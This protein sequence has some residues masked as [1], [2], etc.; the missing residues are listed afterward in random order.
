[1]K[2]RAHHVNE[3][4]RDFPRFVQESRVRPNPG[5]NTRLSIAA[6]KNCARM[7]GPDTDAVFGM[8]CVLKFLP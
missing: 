1:M 3:M 7:P 5:E 4:T 8:D 2:Y 6:L